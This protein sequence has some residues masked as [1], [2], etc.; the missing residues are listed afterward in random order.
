MYGVQS[1]YLIQSDQPTRRH[2]RRLRDDLE[3]FSLKTTI[4]LG[5]ALGIAVV[6]APLRGRLAASAV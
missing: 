5:T 3:K 2:R 6:D 4:N 1:T